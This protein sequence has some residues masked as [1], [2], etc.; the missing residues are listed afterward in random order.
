M[1][2]GKFPKFV[3]SVEQ[4][5]FSG[6]RALEQGQ[7]VHYVTERCVVELRPEGLTV[8]EVA[9]GVDVERDVVRQAGCPLR[10]AADL[11]TMDPRLFD[12]APMRLVLPPG[13]RH[14]T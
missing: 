11:K 13:R 4:V 3:P 14:G 1:R 6:R 7:T 12:P 5:T 8:I 9:P 2:E 10:V